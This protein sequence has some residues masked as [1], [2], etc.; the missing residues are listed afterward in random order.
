MRSAK[1]ISFPIFLFLFNCSLDA[2]SIDTISAQKVFEKGSKGDII[3]GEKN[4]KDQLNNT[5]VLLHTGDS[6]CRK[7]IFRS[8]KKFR[9]NQIK[10]GS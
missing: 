9:R 2:Q 4:K 3:L 8:S 10:K 5:P 1:F 7:D 6:V